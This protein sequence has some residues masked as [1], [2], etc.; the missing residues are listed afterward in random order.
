MIDRVVLLS[1]GCMV[2]WGSPEHMLTHFSSLG[3]ICP[4]RTN[5]ADFILDLSSIDVS[6]CPFRLVTTN[7]RFI[8]VFF[9][10]S[11]VAGL[12]TNLFLRN[13]YITFIL[14]YF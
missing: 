5:P 10:V 1:R 11:C 4:H 3:Y 14:L 2:W 7:R 8:G 9:C 13:I 6:V 12:S